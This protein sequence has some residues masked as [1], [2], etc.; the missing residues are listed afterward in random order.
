MLL[1]AFFQALKN[2]ANVEL[3]L[4]MMA[5]IIVGLIFG[6]IPGL[7]GMVAL[8][9]VLPFAFTMTAE[10]ALIFMTA[11]L[12]VQF[13]GGSI[14]AI[15]LNI[16]GVA[17]SAAT[18]IDGF[19]MTQKGEGGRALGAA[20]MSSSTGSVISAFVALA[21]LPLM[22]PMVIALHSADMVFLPAHVHSS[23][24]HSKNVHIQ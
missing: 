10:Q 18:L 23:C 13:M 6:I 3:L 19:P 11:V 21:M 4:F 15:L 20:L 1:E 5:G 8:A 2:F 22:L 7:S 9:L 14:T 12:A 16:P 24:R 17:A